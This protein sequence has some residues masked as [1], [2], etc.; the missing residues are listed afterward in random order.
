MGSQLKKEDYVNGVKD[1]D[2]VLLSRAI[3]LIESSHPK[4]RLLATEVLEALESEKNTSIRVG[5][6]GVPGAGKSTFIDGLGSFLCKE[7][8]HVAV[9]S[10]DPSSALSGGS[11]LGDKTRMEELS[12]MEN[13]FIRPS[14]SSGVL[15]GV[16]CRTRETIMICEAAGFDVILVETVGVG[17]SEITVS[18]MVDFMLLLALTGAGDDLQTIK[19]GIMELA[20]GIIVNKA[21]GDNQVP[22]EKFAHELAQALHLLYSRHENWSCPVTPHSSLSQAGYK[23]IWEMIL[24]FKTKM[25]LKGW[26]QEH[27]L[28]QSQLW[29]EQRVLDELKA[30]Y[31]NKTDKK[32]SYM[33]MVNKIKSGSLSVS[34][35]IRK[36]FKE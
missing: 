28:E 10:I 5:I 16:A 33:E 4:H 15:G 14:P 11:I 6:T 22:A 8:H 27:R 9:L 2:P 31:F 21:D 19:K 25:E 34:S 36:L 32:D 26:W 23:D 17:Q 30:A 20:D 3:T 1:R 12:R 18:S 13:S 24:S 7:G 35:A 29:F